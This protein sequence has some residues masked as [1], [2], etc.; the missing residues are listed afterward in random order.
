[1]TVYAADTPL[2]IFFLAGSLTVFWKANNSLS[3]PIDC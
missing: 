2:Y 3:H 1:M